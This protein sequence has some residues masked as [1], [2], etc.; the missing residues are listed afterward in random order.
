MP[1]RIDASM[2]VASHDNAMDGS[3]FVGDRGI[4]DTLFNKP[5]SVVP[6]NKAV[7]WAASW[8]R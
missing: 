2:L 3:L 7:H 4:I 5:M 1:F 6:E 8:F